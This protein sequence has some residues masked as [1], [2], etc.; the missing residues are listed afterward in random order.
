MTYLKPKDYDKYYQN[1]QAQRENQEIKRLLNR[2]SGTILDLGCGTGLG[3]SLIPENQRKN[4][5]GVDINQG[6]IDNPEARFE[7]GDAFKLI[8]RFNP[9]NI[10]SLFAI[11][12]MPI[13]IVEKTKQNNYFIIHYNKPYLSGSGSYYADKKKFFREKHPQHEEFVR[14]LKPNMKLLGEDYYFITTNLFK[15]DE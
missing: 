2:I 8:E 7:C 4:Y 15:N 1:P 12:Y 5:I 11:D 13:D 3:A 6:Y 9:E 14:R 10:I